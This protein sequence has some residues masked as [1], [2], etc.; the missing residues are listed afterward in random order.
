MDGS[1]TGPRA[2][3]GPI[4]K[5]LQKCEDLPVVKFRRIECNL[6]F[7]TSTHLS[8]DQQYLLDIC[9]AIDLGECS[10]SLEKHNP[11]KLVHSR[12]LTTGNRILR[13]YMASDRPSEN[14]VILTTFVS[15]VYAPMW[16][17]IKSEPSCVNGSKHVCH[18]IVLSRYLPEELR[19]KIDPVIQR[20]GFFGHPENI[21][22]CMLYDSRQEI[23][24]LS[25]R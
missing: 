11:G 1:T 2:F 5:A 3:A 4:G 21:L 15:K 14:L 7:V 20:N 6:S 25:L 9:R 17:H 18:L 19:D 23:R 10:A 16:F 8:T 24:K 22:L 12:W 13:L